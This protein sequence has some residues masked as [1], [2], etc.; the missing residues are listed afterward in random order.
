MHFS[1]LYKSLG[2]LIVKRVSNDVLLDDPEPVNRPIVF[3]YMPG[4]W[5]QTLEGVRQLKSS[6]ESRGPIAVCGD[7][8][9]QE[10]ARMRAFLG[11]HKK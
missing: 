3:Y 2:D 9:V 4:R 7:V 8:L 10:Q 1:S 5:S 11:V 6:F